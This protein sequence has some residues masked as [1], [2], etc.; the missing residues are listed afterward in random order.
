MTLV[1]I[2]PGPG[3]DASVGELAFRSQAIRFG[4]WLGW[5]SLAVVVAGLALGA[6]SGWRPALFGLTLAAALCN[7]VAAFVPWQRWL[8]RRIGQLLVDAWSASLIGFIALLAVR[9]GANFSLLLFVALP[10]IAV[11]QSG[12]RRGFWLAAS[13]TTCMTAAVVAPFPLVAT[14]TRLGIVAAVVAATLALVGTLQ[15]QIAATDRAAARVELE[16]ALAHEADHRVKNSLQVAADLLLLERPEGSAAS[17]F[18]DTAA[19]LRSIAAVHRILTVSSD[20]IDARA[21][22]TDIAAAGPADVTVDAAPIVLDAPTAR[23]VGIVANELITNAARHGAPPIRVQLRSLHPATQA[24]LLVDDTG[25]SRPGVAALGLRLVRRTVEEGL[26]GSFALERLPLGGT[27]AEV[28]FP[29][30]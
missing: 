13:A 5:L 23:K 11:V 21:L 26:H 25:D 30:A 1:G 9:G 4:L 19:R 2:A 3:S 18:D 24:R 8:Q 14:A 16:R 27:R 7:A 28:T 15:R 20:R 10:F 17:S 29:V 22:L 6:G 12:W